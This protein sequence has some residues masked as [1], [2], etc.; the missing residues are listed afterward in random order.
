ML[1]AKSDRYLPTGM[2]LERSISAAPRYTPSPYAEMEPEQPSVPLSHYLWILR[3]NAWKILGFIAVCM[4]ITFVVSARLQPV[5]E[6]TAKIDVDRRAPSGVIGAESTQ[7]SGVNDAD[8]FLTT[9]IELIQSDAVLRPVAQKFSL[10]E[11][12]KQIKGTQD[13]EARHLANAP[14][15]LKNLKVTR[16]PNSFIL[17]IAYRSPDPELAASVANA[18]AQSYLEHTYNIRIRS[19]VGLSSFMEKQ[20][21]ELRAK[22]ETSG[23]ALAKFERELNVISPE[24]KTNI[25]SAR[26]LQLNTEYTNAQGERVKKEAAFNSMKGNSLAAARVSTQGESL[27][28]L[29]DRLDA[30]KEKFAEVKTTFGANHAEYRKSFNTLVELTRQFEEAKREIGQRVDV[31]YQQAKD[32]EAMLRKSVAET[33]SEF[34]KINLRSYEYQQLKREAEGDKKLYEELVRK[35][36]EAGINAGFQNSAIRIADLARPGAR[37]VFPNKSLNLL[38]AFLLSSVLAIGA[39]ILGDVLDNTVKDPE[40]AMRMLQID[41]IGTLPAVKAP[42]MASLTRPGLSPSPSDLPVPARKSRG[43]YHYKGIGSYEEAVRTLRNSILLGDF[44]RTLHSILVTS[45]TPGEGKSTTAIHLAIAHAEQGKKTL[46]IDADLRRPTMH[47]RLNV[48]NS[49]GLSDALTGVLRWR[50]VAIPAAGRENLHVIPSGPSSRRASD[51]IGPMMVD[52]LDEMSKEYDLIIIDAPP[53]LGFAEPLQM[54]SA[55]DGVLVVTRA[56]E[57]SR[58]A[59]ATVLA[60]LGRLRTNVLGLVLNQVK[61]EMSDSYYYYGYYRKYYSAQ[62]GGQP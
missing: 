49:V 58:K 33:K 43:G 59:V 53:L 54:A 26:L 50:D 6:A 23:Q 27:A 62:A 22:M 52:M 28:K 45:A 37:P 21:D 51:L 17:R 4:V 25:L 36:K 14:A 40:Q 29:Q 35:I 10:L 7:S 47:K 12:E 13:P 41:V 19:S 3:R 55:A 32:R 61:K 34:D 24:E 44:D 1:P 8:Q 42:E 60:T 57:T 48:P 18:I 46:I 30:A 15:V 39:A 20:I 16:P 56:G 2:E 31:D 11:H 38:L 5:Y 9:Q